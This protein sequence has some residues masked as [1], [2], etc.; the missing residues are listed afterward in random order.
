VGFSLLRAI[1]D[2]DVRRTV[3]VTLVSLALI[4]LAYAIVRSASGSLTAL[5]GLSLIAA[6]GVGNLI[7]RVAR[8]YVVDFLHLHHYPVFN[9]AD[10]CV[11]IGAA[12][13]ILASRGARA[14]TRSPTSS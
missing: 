13:V 4:G 11:A 7:D 9:V 12:L 2:D 10:C 5:A 1:A 14:P 6:G 3:I 8:G